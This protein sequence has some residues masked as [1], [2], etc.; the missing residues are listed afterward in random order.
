MEKG[1]FTTRAEVARV[2]FCGAA[3]WVDG[4]VRCEFADTFVSF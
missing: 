4:D 3:G 2:R 1:V